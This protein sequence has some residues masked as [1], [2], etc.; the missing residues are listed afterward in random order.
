MPTAPAA[1][2][3]NADA[4]NL[5]TV[6]IGTILFSLWL[7][8]VVGIGQPLPSGANRCLTVMLRA[9]SH[10]SKD[11]E[12]QI[13]L[14]DL[15]HRAGLQRP[16]ELR[17]LDPDISLPPCTAGF[18][19]PC[20]YLP[21]TLPTSPDGH[22]AILAHEICHIRRHDIWRKLFALTACS[23]HWFNPMAHVILPRMYED[24]EPAC[25]RDT[26]RLLGGKPAVSVICKR[27]S[28]SH[29]SPVPPPLKTHSSLWAETGPNQI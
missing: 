17:I 23:V 8:G 14:I 2:D 5:P 29:P 11:N 16:P 18:F 7:C 27:C 24:L 26:L 1:G 22:A 28:R 4:V 10:P 19:H 3:E 21:S 6:E 9:C 13:I 25:D 12:T 20:I 15:A